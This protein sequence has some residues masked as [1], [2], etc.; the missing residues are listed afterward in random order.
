[1]KFVRDNMATQFAFV[2]K[3]NSGRPTPSTRRLDG[4]EVHE[5]P[6]NVSQSNV[7]VDLHA[8]LRSSA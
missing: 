1:M 3:S 7:L 8:G 2:W 5:G 4:V 6:R